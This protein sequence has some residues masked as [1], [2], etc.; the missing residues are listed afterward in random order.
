MG[1]LEEERAEVVDKFITNG[2]SF[3]IIVCIFSLGFM[4]CVIYNEDICKSKPITSKLKIIQ[5]AH[6]SNLMDSIRIDFD[7]NT[8]L[9]KNVTCVSSTGMSMQPTLFTGN[10]LIIQTYDYRKD[11]LKEGWLVRFYNKRNTTT[12]HRIRG[13]YKN[14]I[15]T[16]GD[17]NGGWERVN[18]TDITH[19]VIGLLYM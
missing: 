4:A 15:V 10:M 1:L 2:L 12:V 16:Q 6:I 5:S 18:K 13:I 9:L 17:S 7:N 19:I 11:N 8:M 14:Y 3:I